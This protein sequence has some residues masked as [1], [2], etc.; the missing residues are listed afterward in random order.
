MEQ[1]TGMLTPAVSDYA[2]L[3]V[4]LSVIVAVGA[5]LA[6]G[7]SS[8]LDGPGSGP[9]LLSR[10]TQGGGTAVGEVALV[11]ALVALAAIY[12]TKN[13]DEDTQSLA[14][15]MGV[16]SFVGSFVFA[17]FVSMGYIFQKTA[18]N[19]FLPSIADAL[20]G[21]FLVAL[22]GLIVGAASVFAIRNLDP[23]EETQTGG[24]QQGPPGGQAPPQGGQGPR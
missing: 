19:I 6:E 9:L 2:V 24:Y 21:T 1:V 11:M 15:S 13:S 17:L 7:I 22:S 12:F 4:V 10:L 16:L 20:I 3:T 23:N 18:N 8:F 14:L 5:G